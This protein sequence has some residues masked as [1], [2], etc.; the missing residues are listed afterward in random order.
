MTVA[1]YRD[2]IT[3]HYPITLDELRRSAGMLFGEEPNKAVLDYVNVDP[4]EAVTP[5]VYD[6]STQA[7]AEGMPSL[8]GATWL[9][10]WAV[11]DLPPQPVQPIIT[12]KSDIWRRCTDAEAAILDNALDEAPVKMRRMWDD[13]TQIES[14]APEFAMFR[15]QMVAAF[16]E[17][18]TAELLAP[19]E[20]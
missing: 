3:G 14:T 15:G 13:S 18:R 10:T 9:Q 2:R 4:V 5:P 12:Y 6:T 1:A 7:L 17:A 16:G 19:S 11:T 20:V 8:S